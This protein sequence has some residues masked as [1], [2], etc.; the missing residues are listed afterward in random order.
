MFKD[1]GKRVKSRREQLG[2]S[3]RRL[4]EESNVSASF[5]S[6]IENNKTFPSMEK[7]ADIAEALNVPI[8]WLLGEKEMD[9]AD[10]VLINSIEKDG[11]MYDLFLNKHT[12]PNG[13]T[14]EQMCAKIKLL[15][16]LQSVLSK[17]DSN[18]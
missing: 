15:D 4:G 12:F 8:S 2:F 10:D 13:L 16:K 11:I 9:N 14:Y 5:L 18:K 17:E 1:F 3:L 7:A 6:D